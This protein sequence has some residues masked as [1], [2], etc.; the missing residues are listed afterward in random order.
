MATGEAAD[1]VDEVPP[2]AEIVGGSVG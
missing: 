2:A 1:R